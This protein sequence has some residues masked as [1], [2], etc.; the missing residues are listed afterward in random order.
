MKSITILGS[1]GSIGQ[2]TL[3]IVSHLPDCFK[4]VALSAHSNLTLLEQQIR[5]Y[6]P[7]VVAVADEKKATEL[8]K[9]G[10]N[11]KI[12]FGKEGL[13]EVAAWQSAE[14]VVVAIVGLAAL[15]PTIAAIAAGKAIGL[16]NKEVLVSAGKLVMDLAKKFKVP[17]IPIDSEH[18]AIFQCLEGRDLKTISRVVLTASGGP[19]RNY[20]QEELSSITLEQALCHPTWK[21][22]PK[23]TVDSSTLMNKGLELIEAHFLFDIPP[24]KLDVVIHPQS[25]IHSLIEFID[26]SVIAQLSDPN[27]IYPIQYALTYPERKKG[28]FPPFDFVKN[29]KL[30]F[31][32]PDFQKFPAL[33]FALDSLKSGG[34][35]P[36][37][38]NAA[39]EVL[40][41][42]F[43]KKAISWRQISDCLQKLISS[44]HIVSTNSIENVMTV[45]SQG[46]EDALKVH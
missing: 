23:I 7:E 10:L 38:L 44:H 37:Y 12:V 5:E 43:L 33:K 19:F 15:A 31:F 6:K 35:L 4:V 22:G 29:S 3:K 28:M 32:P 26:G 42:R 21:M 34:S 20:S 45:D 40:V 8:K 16:A 36:C 11:V 25:I 2:S 13:E 1:T 9:R 14:F 39:N 41:D 17:L 18:S 30:E 27:M 24:E 46:R